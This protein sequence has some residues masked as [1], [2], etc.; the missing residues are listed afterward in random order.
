MSIDLDKSLRL[1]LY[2][3]VS[4]GLLVGLGDSIVDIEILVNLLL[5]TTTLHVTC[6]YKEINTTKENT[7]YFTK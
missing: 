1:V 2:A 5:V 7:N 3:R 4:A 6:K